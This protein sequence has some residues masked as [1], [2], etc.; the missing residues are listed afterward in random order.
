MRPNVDLLEPGGQVFPNGRDALLGGKHTDHI[1]WLYTYT[2]KF[3]LTEGKSLTDQAVSVLAGRVE[4]RWFVRYDSPLILS[5]M[6]TGLEKLIHSQRLR[7]FRRTAH[8]GHVATKK[9][10]IPDTIIG[11]GGVLA[12]LLQLPIRRSK[13]GAPFVE[14]WAG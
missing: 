10:H 8:S 4:A 14:P 9:R 5:H 2:C 3:P 11:P 12:S 13:V 6:C 1:L 7:P